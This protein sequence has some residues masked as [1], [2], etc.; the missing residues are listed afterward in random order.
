MNPFYCEVMKKKF[1]YLSILA[2]SSVMLS[3]C[4]VT[5]G[6]HGHVTVGGSGGISVDSHGNVAAWTDASYDSAG[7]PIYG[8]YYGRP[9][10]GYDAYGAAVF[11]FGALTAACIVPAWGPAP[12]CAR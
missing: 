11:T 2:A 1:I 12:W 5:A 10:Y 4:Y 8:Y 7:F 6:P 3:S 9:V